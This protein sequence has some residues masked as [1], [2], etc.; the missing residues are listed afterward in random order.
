MRTLSKPY[1]DLTCQ[2]PD[3]KVSEKFQRISGW[4]DQNPTVLERVAQDLDYDPDCQT[5]ARGLAADSVLRAAIYQACERLT[6]RELEFALTDSQT[7]SE[8]NAAKLL[9]S[10]NQ[11]C[12][13]R[14]AN[15]S[16]LAELKVYRQQ[17]PLS[18]L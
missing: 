16:R 7:A 2:Y 12:P 9:L 11:E 10:W 1:Q 18:C 8:Q 17:K 4:I 5:G 6:F 13:Q 3:H 14:S 15:K